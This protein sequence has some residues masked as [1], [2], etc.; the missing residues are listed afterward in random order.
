MNYTH[1]SLQETVVDKD[2]GD[3]RVQRQ[4][5]ECHFHGVLLGDQQGRR[6]FSFSVNVTERQSQSGL[7]FYLDANVI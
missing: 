6:D 7:L 2:A 5:K 4:T 1:S 3:Q